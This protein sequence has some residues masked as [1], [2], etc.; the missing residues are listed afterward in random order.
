MANA[1][2]IPEKSQISKSLEKYEN[3]RRVRSKVIEEVRKQ[4][5]EHMM[6]IRL[7]NHPGNMKG[8]K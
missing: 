6:Y 4:G 8:K 5:R 1:F 3:Q 7:N 2:D